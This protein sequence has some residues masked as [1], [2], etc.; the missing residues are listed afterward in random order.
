MIDPKEVPMNSVKKEKVLVAMSGGVDSAVCAY[1]LQQKGFEVEGLT[2]KLWSEHETVTDE[3]DTPPDQN[4]LDARTVADQLRIPHHTVALGDTFRKRVVERFIGDY[5]SGQTPNP[6]VECNKY[7]KFGRLMTLR[8]EMG[9]DRLATGH[10]AKIVQESSGNFVL[11]KASDSSKDQSYFLWSI[12]KESLPRILFPLG[13]Y[14]KAEIR[15]IAALRQLACATRSDSQDIC[16]IPNGDYISFINKHCDHDFPE[17][18]FISPDGTVLGQHGGI[19]RYTVGQRKGLG[20]AM[21]YPIFVGR[22]N[23][24]NNTVTLCSDAELYTDRLSATKINLLVND[25]FSS[26]RRLEAKIRYRHTPAAA[27]VQRVGEDRLSVVFDLPQ[28]AIAPGQSLVLYDGDTVI[29]G[30]IIE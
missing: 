16:F 25:E 20:I 3:I 18:D 11:K 9:F 10:Y 17:G 22:K 27:T 2:M 14:S 12:Q 24:L 5:V 7:I 26:P 13:G 1:L 23:A 8:D 21:G 6:C 28:R 30:G 15:E 4:C 19:I 29:G